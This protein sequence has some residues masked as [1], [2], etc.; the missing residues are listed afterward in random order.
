MALAVSGVADF[1]ASSAFSSGHPGI[2]RLPKLP[3]DDVQGWGKLKRKWGPRP[4]IEG[5]YAGYFRDPDGN[6]LNAFFMPS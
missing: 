1:L 3:A 5:F 4:G 6:K 2:G